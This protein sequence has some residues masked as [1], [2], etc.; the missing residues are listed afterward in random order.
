MTKIS[1]KNII[2]FIELGME[3]LDSDLR[4]LAEKK[5]KIILELGVDILR[6]HKGVNFVA[7]YGKNRFSTKELTPMMSHWLE[8]C[9]EYTDRFG[10]LDAEIKDG[11]IIYDIERT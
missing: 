8:F 10:S 2:A 1:K 6:Y 11:K 7:A 5:R 9:Q 4:E 3:W